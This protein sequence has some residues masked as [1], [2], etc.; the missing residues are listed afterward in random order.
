M[1]LILSHPTGNANVRAA[2]VGLAKSGLLAKFYTTIAAYPGDIAYKAGA[3]GPF[4]E[5]RRRTYDTVLQGTTEKWPW[6]EAG[7]LIATKLK[8]KRLIKHETGLLSIDA[9]YADLD[10]HIAS[11]LKSLIVKERINGSYC[12]EDG[13]L[14]TFRQAKRLQLSCLYDLPIGYWRCSKEILEKEKES[15][16]EWA[17][18]LS[19]LENSIEKLNRK[20]EELKMADRIFVASSFTASTLQYYPGE[21]APVDVIPYGFPPV[22]VGR[23]YNPVA[24]KKLKVLFVGGLSQRKG[25]ANLFSAVEKLGKY[26]DLTVVGRK[27]KLDCPALNQELAK[28]KWISSLP[29][30]KILKLMQENDIL[31]FPS[32]FEGFGLVITEAMSQGTPVITTERTCGPDIINNN[33]NGWLIKAGQTALLVERLENCISRPQDIAA[34]G[35]EAMTTA[36]G[37]P[38]DLYGQQLATAV[39]HHFHFNSFNRV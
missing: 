14:H 12:Y 26:I 23:V 24:N 25:I 9:V 13:A 8:L 21:L 27:P 37:R 33:E 6:R 5:I 10:K 7:R 38:W 19:G 3:I 30:E 22:A 39:G 4:S 29:H 28:H 20:D 34:I 16:P 2:A 32:L 15:W 18:T 31:V 11:H 17:A 35:R 36:A 1:K